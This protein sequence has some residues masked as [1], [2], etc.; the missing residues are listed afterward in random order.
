SFGTTPSA[1]KTF[2]AVG[3]PMAYVP[4]AKVLEVCKAVMKV[5]RDFG[6]RSDRKVARLKYLIHNWGVDRFKQK[7]EEYLGEELEAPR[8]VVVTG[9]NDTLGWHEQG[10][11]KWFYG[12]SI[13]NGRIKDTPTLK[14]KTALREACTRFGFPLRLTAQQNIVFCD[15]ESHQKEE[16]LDVFRRHEVALTHEIS[17]VRRWSMACP[18]LPMCGLSV[19]ESERILPS[20]IDLMEKDL[21][22][23]GL[24]DEIFTTHM[25]GCPNGCARPYNSDIGIVGKAKNKYTIF[26][27]GHREGDRLNWIYKDM[28]PEDQVVS[29]LRPVFAYFAQARQ[30]GEAF[31][32]F[33]HRVG[34]EELLRVCD[35]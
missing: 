12:L 7:V 25:T 8:P 15:V 18:A 4:A 31:G 1:A 13:E 20:L 19:T 5:Q 23:L 29:T 6:N 30:P 32:D 10:D 16:L 17:T 14:L 26:L 28:V 11:G 22:E 21:A 3:K 33:C 34:Q 9:Y 27:G 2:P 24:S 35:N